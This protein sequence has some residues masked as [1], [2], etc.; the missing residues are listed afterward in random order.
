[1]LSV[2]T[3]GALSGWTHVLSLACF[4]LSRN[5]KPAVVVDSTVSE[6]AL[7]SACTQALRCQHCS[8]RDIP[9]CSLDGPPDASSARVWCWGERGGAD[10]G[11]GLLVEPPR[12]VARSCPRSPSRI[13]AKTPR[14][15]SRARRDDASTIHPW[16]A[17]TV[18]FCRFAGRLSCSAA[19]ALA[20]L[21]LAALSISTTFVIA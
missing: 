4:R 7:V 18:P 9:P 19:A 13:A 21:R 14:C 3:G 16:T 6:V 5:F 2:K 15:I 11:G 12:C 8:R 20:A 1:M 17:R 10:G